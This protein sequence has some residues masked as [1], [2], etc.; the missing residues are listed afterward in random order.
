[1]D[2]TDAL[3]RMV[4]MSGKPSSQV[5][6]ELGRAE[7]FVR[8][9][10]SQGTRPRVDTFVEIARACGYEVVLRSVDDEFTL[11]SFMPRVVVEY[12]PRERK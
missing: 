4:K 1:M 2:P 9:T 11:D 3:K 7:S 5:A 6:R 12:L 8:A 10:I